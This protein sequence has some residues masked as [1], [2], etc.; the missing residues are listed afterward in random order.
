MKTTRRLFLKNGGIAIASVG[1]VPA[2][3]PSFLQRAAYASDSTA[4]KRKKTLICLFMRGAAD[5]LS[6]VVPYGEDELYR[7]RPNI[8]IPKNQVIDLDGFFGLHPSLEPFAKIYKDGH[9][10]VI[11]ACGSPS[12]TRS[13]FDAMDYMES[14]SPG[15]KSVRDG[16]LARAAMLCPQD[17]AAQNGQNGPKSPFR[18]VALGGGLP[19][20]LQGD[21]GALAIPNLRTFG[22]ADGG[23]SQ[24][25]GSGDRRR[26]GRGLGDDAMMAAA[27]T[28]GSTASGF[29]ALYDSAVGDVLHGTGK[30]SFEALKMMRRINPANYTPDANARYPQGRL[31]ESLMQIAQLVKADVGVEVAFADVGGWD[32]HAN[33]VQP[34]NATQGNLPNRLRELG[35]A[36]SALYYDLGDRMNDV[37]IL[38][39]SEFGRT[40]RQNGTGGTDHGH[41]SCFFVMGG[42]VVGGKVHGDWPGLAPEKLYEGRDL[43]LTTDFR[44]VF[45]ELAVNHLGVQSLE[46][47]FP[48]YEGGVKSFRGLVRPR[49]GAHPTG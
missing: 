22:I 38:T 10:A 29:E 23:D 16:W 47:L 28:P 11:H 8:A 30:E 9:L 45:G 18:A 44:A 41:A 49:S 6:V 46:K 31:G 35:Q 20:S 25:R 42:P 33:Q 14:G 2:F 12:S 40:V 43:A 7:A 13:H 27:L 26:G 24:R 3:G 1:L 32:T 4:A 21:A 19:R 39:M 37:V 17:R 34:G 36:L 15:S 5:G 48:G